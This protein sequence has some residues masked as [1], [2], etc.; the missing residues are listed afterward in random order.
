MILPDDS[1]TLLEKAEKSFAENRYIRACVLYEKIPGHARS[2]KDSFQLGQAYLERKR[3]EQALKSLQQALDKGYD[4]ISTHYAIGQAKVGMGKDEGAL[5]EF[6][7]SIKTGSKQEVTFLAAGQIYERREIYNKAIDLYQRAA[8]L[9]GATI[10]PLLYLAR[11]FDLQGQLIETV[12][13]LKM[14][15]SREPMNRNPYEILIKILPKLSETDRDAILDDITEKV[16]NSKEYDALLTWMEILTESDEFIKYGEK[17]FIEKVTGFWDHYETDESRLDNELRL[18]DILRRIEYRDDL[19]NQVKY[20]LDGLSSALLHA[21][22]GAACT[23]A[24]KRDEAL[25]QFELALQRD[26]KGERILEIAADFYFNPSHIE[27]PDILARMEKIVESLGEPRILITWARM[28][29]YFNKNEQAELYLQRADKIDNPSLPGQLHSTW[30][31]VLVAQGKHVEAISHILTMLHLDPD[32]YFEWWDLGDELSK[33]DQPGQW[34]KDIN[35][36]LDAT[37]DPRMLIKGAEVLALTGSSVLALDYLEKA[38]Q[39]DPSQSD[40]YQ[41]LG[42]ILLKLDN[43]QT[44]IDRIGILVKQSNNAAASREWSKA[45]DNIGFG[46]ESIGFIEEAI[47]L[48]PD[49]YQ[50]HLFLAVLYRK[51]EKFEQAFEL[52]LL[53]VEEGPEYND[54]YISWMDSLLEQEKKNG[55]T[56]KLADAL[57]NEDIPRASEVDLEDI[58]KTRDRQLL[59]VERL[60]YNIERWCDEAWVYVNCGVKIDTNMAAYTLNS[61]ERLY[62]GGADLDPKNFWSFFDLGIVKEQ[63]MQYRESQEAFVKARELAKTPKEHFEAQL[64]CARSL[65]NMQKLVDADQAYK[66]TFEANI[67]FTGDYDLKRRAESYDGWALL[68]SNMKEFHRSLDVSHIALDLAPQDY[69]T[70]FRLAYTYSEMMEYDRSIAEYETAITIDPDHPYAMH[71]IAYI[72]ERQGLYRIAR[73]QWNATLKVYQAGL[74]KAIRNRDAIYCAN[75]GDVMSALGHLEQA[76]SL[77]RA[78]EILNPYSSFVQKV[79]C[80]I[81]LEF[82][83][84]GRSSAG[85]TKMKMPLKSETSAA[86]HWRSQNAYQK[87]KRLLDARLSDYRN[88]QTLLE[89]G[90]IDLLKGEYEAAAK[91]LKEVVAMNPSNERAYQKLGETYLALGRPKE[92]ITFLVEALSFQPDDLAL[93]TVLARAYLRAGNHD[94]AEREFIRVADSAKF[95]VDAWIGLGELY[96]EMAESKAAK[97]TARMDE[98]YD[99]AIDALVRG[100]EIAKSPD[101]PITITAEMD[102]AY[103]LLGYARIQLY[104]SSGLLRDIGMVSQAQADF[105]KCLKLNPNYTKARRALERIKE[106]KGRGRTVVER[107]GPYLVIV[108]SFLIIGISLFGLLKGFAAKEA[109]LVLSPSSIDSLKGL[110]L[111]QD[112]IDHLKR[113]M[114]NT[115]FISEEI[116]LRR[117]RDIL[118]ADVSDKAMI[119]IRQGITLIPAERQCFKIGE[120]ALLFFGGLLFLIASVY[121]PQLTSLKLP[122]LQLD[123][124]ASE[125]VEP[126]RSLDISK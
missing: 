92:A 69:W 87:A 47:R 83:K 57:G 55:V 16:V 50:A 9:Q 17:L 40:A 18:A 29:H 27:A 93:R 100:I 102:T 60:V 46:I 43:K 25:E 125:R 37:E 66:E 108:L 114:E 3:Y 82:I 112:Q 88:S 52:H 26:T 23:T 28:L 109:G 90:T 6:E 122:G 86:F 42:D 63:K 10:E 78:A 14:A 65:A 13:A 111:K 1:R 31:D 77:L 73:I 120:F 41:N 98:W 7:A 96:L 119:A 5:L 97:D 123:K 121:L 54:V 20:V 110:N 67:Y 51:E 68:L 64:A 36:L 38:L 126:I 84:K 85:L 21:V 53:A 124:S 45:L 105:R 95:C 117:V 91:V 80:D 72:W 58:R 79:L 81:Y 107:L 113:Q 116:L 101:R 34:T 62:K 24:A 118:G 48:D 12:N 32:G 11:C 8:A 115:R 15:I 94:E 74:A 56:V 22:W 103:Y 71:N 30:K 76:E 104:E 2:G 106:Q 49:D 75:Y 59:D 99:R 19:A 44:V 89:L 61:S 33:I 39:L 4:S 35:E 70:Q